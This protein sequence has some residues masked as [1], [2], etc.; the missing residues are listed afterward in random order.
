MSTHEVL[1]Q[2][3]ACFCKQGHLEREMYSPDN[4]Y[5]RPWTGEAKVQCLVCSQEWVF[6]YNDAMR[7]A[8][9]DKHSA[10][11]PLVFRPEWKFS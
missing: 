11:A 5:S 9:N 10:G 2:R 1:C 3:A 7:R 6:I 8:S 4:P